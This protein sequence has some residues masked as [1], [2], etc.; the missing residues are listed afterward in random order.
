[1]F[2][3]FL[4]LLVQRRRLRRLAEAFGDTAIRRLFPVD[5]RRFPVARLACLATAGLAICLA[6]S[7]PRAVTGPGAGVPLDIAIA[8]D[9][10]LSMNASDI[11]PTRIERARDVVIQV[12]QQVPK[13][14]LSLVVFGDWPY[15]LVP[16]TEDPGV[17]AY[18]A[19]SLTGALVS[20]LVSSIRTRSG[21]QS[22]SLQEALMQARTAL[23]SRPTAGAKRV[24]LLV[25]DGALSGS[26][27]D[28]RNWAAAG[29]EAA[30]WTAGIGKTNGAKLEANG[31]SVV[32]ASGDLPTAG[33]DAR[34]LRSV[35]LAGGGVY[36]DVSD[37]RGVRAL[38]SRLRQLSGASGPGNVGPE[39]AAFWLG[40]LA[41]ALL[42]WEG[43]LDAGKRLV[44]GRSNEEMV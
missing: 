23:D 8:V 22:A 41:M 28:V 26:A 4:A 43:G 14:R 6:A 30:V 12:S 13:G 11:R 3:F 1:V 9:L 36:E 35:A 15:T 42:L 33:F 37:D 25:S 34:L 40:V 32:G 44:F 16:P 31:R 29:K 27:E 19:E 39:R 21:D 7:G 17:V 10:S 24:I 2:A 38:V 18:F 20:K 5:T